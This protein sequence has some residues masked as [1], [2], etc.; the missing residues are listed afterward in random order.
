MNLT[1]LFSQ[2]LAP[3]VKPIFR[4]RSTCIYV[5]FV[6]FLC[7]FPMGAHVTAQL[8]ERKQL[9]KNEAEYLLSFCNNIGP[10]YFVSFA[11]PVM[12]IKNTPLALLGMYGIPLL[13]GLIL[14]YT[15]YA[16]K[17]SGKES[18][19]EK[20]LSEISLLEALDESVISALSGITKLGGY[21]I[22]FNLLYI[23]PQLLLG[24]RATCFL[25]CLFEIT[26]GL[27]ILKNELPILSL[28]ML[29]FG[30]LSCLAQTY[31]MI[32]NTN[33]SIYHYI[34]HKLILT[35]FS[36]VYYFFVVL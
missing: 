29:T 3:F 35:F 6:G 34:L 33:L 18:K 15:S 36:F 16:G 26:G 23:F 9:T 30:G 20:Y 13:Y 5:I 4:I 32:K 22:I 8:Y 7:G 25:G 17:I 27:Q 12:G 24:N 28:S 14:R 1:D 11:L 21:M 10:V 19:K 2:L 31:G